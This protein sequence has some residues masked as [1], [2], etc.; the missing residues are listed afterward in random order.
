MPL[1]KGISE[2]GGIAEKAHPLALLAEKN[3][4]Y[5]PPPPKE[6]DPDGQIQSLRFFGLG[7]LLQAPGRWAALDLPSALAATQ[8]SRGH[9]P[10]GLCGCCRNSIFLWQLSGNML[11]PGKLPALLSP[12]RSCLW[13]CASDQGYPLHSWCN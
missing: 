10:L 9:V 11:H 13:K 7:S 3:S 8:L 2:K 12:C 5:P 4:P 6:L 1:G